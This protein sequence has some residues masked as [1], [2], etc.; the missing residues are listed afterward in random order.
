MKYDKLIA[1]L[2]ILYIVGV[3]IYMISHRLWFSPD[4]FFLFALFGAIFLGR[5]RLFILDWGPF[6]TGFFSY[7]F[8]R[9]LIPLISK[10]V[11]IF[12]MI[13][14][15]LWL[16]GF[17]PSVKLQSMLYSPPNL[18]WYDYVSVTLYICHFV[19]PL[20]V[21]FIFWLKDRGLF[22][23][24]SLSL[25]ILSYLGFFT[26]IIFPA[27]PPWMASVNGYIPPIKEVTGTV[28]AH[29]LPTQFSVPTLYSLMRANPVA[30]VPSLHAAFPLLILFF[31]IKKYSKKGLLFIPYVLGVWFAVMYLGEHYFIDIVI[32]AIYACVV[33]FLIE[34]RE[35]LLKNFSMRIHFRRWKTVLSLKK[36]TAA[37]DKIMVADQ[38]IPTSISN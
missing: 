20:V 14:A 31:L 29:F 35:F 24:Y 36:K 1:L 27:M 8:L 2:P 25:I 22:K 37:K 6:L 13:H 28:M 3:C 15:D 12:P 18:H 5:A 19:T 30:A 10:K 9:G 16:F 17:I 7:E 26:Y 4:Q 32:G 33:F 11:H 21:G 38:T 23:L 34:K